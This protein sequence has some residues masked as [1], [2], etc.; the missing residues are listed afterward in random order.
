MKLDSLSRKKKLILLGGCLAL[1]PLLLIIVAFLPQLASK[2][3]EEQT[4]LSQPIPEADIDTA[5]DGK[6][7]SYTRSGI[8]DYWDSLEEQNTD[9]SDW[10]DGYEDRSGARRDGRRPEA[11]SVED[12]FGDVKDA[13]PESEAPKTSSPKPASKGGGGGGTSRRDASSSGGTSAKASSRP[14]SGSATSSSS[15]PKEE[16]SEETQTRPQ[17]KRSGAISSLDEDVSQDLGNGF[18]TLDGTDMWVSGEAGKPYRCM[19]TRD[20]KVRTG[21]RISL[22]LLEDLVIGGVHVPKNTHLQGVCSISDRMEVRITSLDM[23]GKI[24]SFHFEAYDTDGGKGIY[25][26]DLSK[27]KKEITDQGI[28]TVMTGLNSR[29]G[30]AARDAA[31]VGASIIRTKTGEVS[32]SVPAGYTFYIVEE[33]R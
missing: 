20:E 8:S 30:M 1:V 27:T 7:D 9:E 4:T 21:Q 22:R 13:A 33:K 19:F 26:S 2:E 3:V 15:S 12:M 24:L 16:T 25:C 29:L 14:S 28:S 23:G 32:V 6:T 31:N 18:S 17:V 5:P 10:K 11:V